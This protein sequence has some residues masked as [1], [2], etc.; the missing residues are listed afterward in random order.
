MMKCEHW[1]FFFIL[2][3]AR[4]KIGFIMTVII[5]A[6]VFG[7]FSKFKCVK[8]LVA[9]YSK[10]HHFDVMSI[11]YLDE[12]YFKNCFAMNDIFG[13]INYQTNN[14]NTERERESQINRP[15]AV[16]TND[17]YNILSFIE[18]Y[19]KKDKTLN[20]IICYMCLIANNFILYIFRLR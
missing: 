9:C 11:F 16:L 2:D 10:P 6:F 18:L 14:M 5:V 13:W 19:K 3:C 8:I 1:T 17:Q 4:N 12:S 20:I 15:H 7:Y